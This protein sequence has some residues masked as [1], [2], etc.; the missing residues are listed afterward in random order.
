MASKR[1][2]AISATLRP[3]L[4]LFFVVLL[5][6]PA[7]NAF[8]TDGTSESYAQFPRWQA[9]L[10]GSIGFEFKSDRPDGLLLYTDDGGGYDFFELRLENRKL[11]IRL[12]LNDREAGKKIAEDYRDLNDNQWHKVMM[13]RNN[14]ETVLSIDDYKMSI[15]LSGTEFEFGSIEKNS[16]VFLGGMPLTYYMS[17]PDLLSTLALPSVVMDKRW[18][19]Q[20]RNVQYSN[21][22]C[23]LRTAT[24]MK[25]GGAR[26]D[27][28]CET[29]N[30]CDKSNPNCD[31]L[32]DKSDKPQCSCTDKSC[33]PGIG[34]TPP[35]PPPLSPLPGASEHCLARIQTKLVAVVQGSA[36][37]VQKLGVVHEAILGVKD[38]IGATGGNTE[39]GGNC[40]MTTKR[41]VSVEL[42]KATNLAIKLEAEKRKWTATG[43]DNFEAILRRLLA[44]RGRQ[45]EDIKAINEL[46]LTA[47]N[48]DAIKKTIK[49]IRQRIAGRRALR[50]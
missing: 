24:I 10:N 16:F 36:R 1:R 44:I 47:A 35:P 7:S 13:K 19:G 31:C 27:N 18:R 23:P 33:G 32:I 29:N 46:P 12:K 6:L 48:R 15:E 21:C 4:F 40:E 30:P 22:S 8:F 9:C 50:K 45:L 17:N 39:Q 3:F 25:L 11:M 38:T 34:A 28:L 2:D 43:F 41:K 5:F 20:M 42:T 14:K 49:R 37:A 26:K